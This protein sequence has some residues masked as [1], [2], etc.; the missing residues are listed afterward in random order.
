[1]APQGIAHP[2][3]G[4]ETFSAAG[5]C[6]LPFDLVVPQLEYSIHAENRAGWWSSGPHLVGFPS[7]Y[8]TEFGQFP[9][10]GSGMETGIGAGARAV[11]S[12][13]MGRPCSAPNWAA[14]IAR[15][16][17]LYPRPYG[18]REPVL[19]FVHWFDLAPGDTAQVIVS[20]D[21]LASWDVLATFTGASSGWQ[22]YTLDLSAW[23][24]CPTPVIVGF[25]LLARAD[26]GGRPGWFIDLF[27]LE[28]G[29]E[30]KVQSQ[31]A[32]SLQYRGPV[33][34]PGGH[35]HP[36]TQVTTC[37]GYADGIFTQ[38]LILYPRQR[39]RA[40]LRVEAPLPALAAGGPPSPA[41]RW[42]WI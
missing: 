22:T 29:G 30:G 27:S 26:G 42:S 38:F 5:W 18:D 15:F 40:D 3:P 13:N 34:S 16:W 37:T 4:T 28:V 10:A 17:A 14:A 1:M 21:N 7:P 12:L 33:D 32:T 11:P 35:R 39:R 2:W 9:W 25:D 23:E 19:R 41:K 24:N 8:T 31:A 20:T 36:E 6:W